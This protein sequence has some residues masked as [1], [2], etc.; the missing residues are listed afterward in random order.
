MQTNPQEVQKL[1]LLLNKLPNLPE[2]QLRSLLADLTQ[3][4]RLKDRELA[5]S[6]FLTFVKRV[7]PNFIEGRHHK[8]MASAFEK[9]ASGKIKRLIINMPPRQTIS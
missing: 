9:V 8:K 5:A 1:K 3:H 7:W 4:E 6:N 2:S